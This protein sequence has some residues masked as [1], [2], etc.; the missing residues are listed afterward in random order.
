MN[1]GKESEF[2]ELL[3]DLRTLM[4]RL[5][6]AI[7]DGFPAHSHE[8]LA[9]AYHA[10]DRHLPKPPGPPSPPAMRRREFS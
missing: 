10:V 2:P 7:I 5:R 8:G 1:D 6:C 9:L 3:S 4:F